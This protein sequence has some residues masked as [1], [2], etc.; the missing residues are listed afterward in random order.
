MNMIYPLL[1]AFCCSL[2]VGCAKT[3]ELATAADQDELQ[4]YV[5]EH[6]SQTVFN[7]E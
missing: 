7:E 3:G 5:A 2:L 1:L 6:G 4:A